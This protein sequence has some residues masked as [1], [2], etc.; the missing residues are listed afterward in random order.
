MSNKKD[1]GFLL[2]VLRSYL[3]NQ[4]I[5]YRQQNYNLNQALRGDIASFIDG[6]SAFEVTSENLSDTQVRL[7]NNE[8]SLVAPLIGKTKK[9]HYQHDS[10]RLYQDFCVKHEE[11]ISYLNNHTEMHFRNIYALPR[12]LQYTVESPQ[13]LTL[14]FYLPTG[15]FA[16]SL[17]EALII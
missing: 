1:R 5:N 2:S 6:K 13:V 9:L 11:I 12:S 17:L 10:L 16:T 3:F 7:N 8:I 4:Y 14:S 15:A